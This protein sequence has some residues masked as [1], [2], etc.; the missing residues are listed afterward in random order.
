MKKQSRHLRPNRVKQKPAIKILLVGEYPLILEALKLCFAG[1]PQFVVV[2]T[3]RGSA[4]WPASYSQAAPDV[5]LI[6]AAA[7]DEIAAATHRAQSRF[8]SARI[9]ALTGSADHQIVAGA[10]RAGA[11]GCLVKN[12]SASELFEAVEIV[13]TGGAF[14]SRTISDIAGNEFIRSLE[15]HSSDGVGRLK[16]GERR[17]L[18]LLANGY[19]N[20][21]MASELNISVRTVEK[22]RESLTNKLG[23]RSV[24]GLTKFAIRNGIATLE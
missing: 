14:F 12:C 17:V 10:V 24:A 2:G 5:V 20:K 9:V 11:R 21:E 22:Y 3:V 13:S 23:I 8:P 4:E 6:D 19:S 18:E 1:R 16:S 7:G 15:N